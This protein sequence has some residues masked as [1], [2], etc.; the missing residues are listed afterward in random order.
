MLL[1]APAIR[2]ASA[3]AGRPPVFGTESSSSATA[4]ASVGRRSSHA[5]ASKI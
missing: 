4:S 3:N 1:L 2:A 5:G